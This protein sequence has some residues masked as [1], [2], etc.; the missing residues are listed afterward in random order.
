MMISFENIA[1]IQE[2][3]FI[4]PKSWH[5]DGHHIGCRAGIA[6]GVALGVMMGVVVSDFVKLNATK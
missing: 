4:V 6:T 1:G 2:I 5:H 3:H